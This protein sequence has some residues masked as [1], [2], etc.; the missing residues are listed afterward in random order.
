MKIT[1]FS[2]YPERLVTCNVEAFIRNN[3]SKDFAE[4]I[5]HLTDKFKIRLIAAILLFGSGLV[6]SVNRGN[7]G[8]SVVMH[9]SACFDY[10]VFNL[11]VSLLMH[12][13]VII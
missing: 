5:F 3:A 11:R 1:G 6:F 7:A 2:R 10:L 8:L 4:I 13:Y 12:D 9:H